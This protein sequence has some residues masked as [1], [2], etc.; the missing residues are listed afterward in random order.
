MK[1]YPGES[2][3][4][5]VTGNRG[6]TTLLRQQAEDAGRKLHG[7]AREPAKTIAAG[8]RE[9]IPLLQRNLARYQSI[10]AGMEGFRKFLESRRPAPAEDV[11]RYI[12]GIR[13]RGQA[14]LDPYRARLEE[15]NAG[16][17]INTLQELIR[18]TRQTIERYAVQLSRLETAEQ[19]S[20][21]LRTGGNHLA[22]ML[23]GIK[24]EGSRLLSVEA[25]NV[26]DLLS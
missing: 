18:D 2:T 4:R 1:I 22:G 3:H 25:E 11:S 14:V 20:R 17:D 16:R 21:S 10:L 19:N 23:R 5:K 15:L 26:L 24:K 9:Q 6:E 7:V 13:Y 8:I 12:D